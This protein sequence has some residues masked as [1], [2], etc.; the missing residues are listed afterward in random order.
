MGGG[1]VDDSRVSF[2]S[3]LPVVCSIRAGQYLDAFKEKTQGEWISDPVTELFIKHIGVSVEPFSPELLQLSFYLT[4]SFMVT[5]KFVEQVLA[6]K[7]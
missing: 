5:A 7:S 4:K 2:H 3:F 6:E 1:I